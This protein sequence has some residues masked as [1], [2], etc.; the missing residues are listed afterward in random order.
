MTLLHRHQLLTNLHLNCSLHLTVVKL[1]A[2]QKRLIRVTCICYVI[3][4]AHGLI[5]T[6]IV[7]SGTNLR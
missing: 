6:D 2:K 4:S 7:A 1:Q 5:F 3:N